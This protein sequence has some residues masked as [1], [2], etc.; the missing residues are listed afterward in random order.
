MT[1][2]DCN[3]RTDEPLRGLRILH[4]TDSF[5]PNVGGLELSIAA[6]VRAQVARGQVVAVVAPPHPEAAAREALDGAVIYRLPMTMARVPG[7]YID[8]THLFF[9]PVPDPQFARAFADV[10]RHF[11]PDVIHARG[12]ILY[13]VLGAARRAGVPVVATAH[14]HSQVC[15]DQ[16]HAL[17]GPPP[18]LG[19]GAAQVHGVRLHALR[20]ER[21]SPGRRSSSARLATASQRRLLDG[22]F[23][24]PRCQRLGATPGR[25]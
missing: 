4:A 18:L 5:L 11:R 17:R 14:D 9:P 12:W 21:D 22:Y 15:A 24:G 10:I 13:S 19:A 20:S 3:Q 8:R 6:L 25:P 2:S 16:D 1:L 23:L 7:A